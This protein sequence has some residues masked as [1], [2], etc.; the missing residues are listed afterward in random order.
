[1]KKQLEDLR[2]K[3]NHIRSLRTRMKSVVFVV[4]PQ[5]SLLNNE[6]ENRYWCYS[7]SQLLKDNKF[8]VI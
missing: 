3:L 2:I 6:K 5:P 1:M 7:V 8:I 4:G